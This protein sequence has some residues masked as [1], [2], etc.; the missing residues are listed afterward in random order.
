MP[1]EH[2]HSRNC[3][4][5]AVMKNQSRFR[6]LYNHLKT[7]CTVTSSVEFQADPM[8]QGMSIVEKR[9]FLIFSASFCQVLKSPKSL[10]AKVPTLEKQIFTK[11]QNHGNK[12]E[13][14]E[15]LAFLLCSFRKS[16]IPSQIPSSKLQCTW[17]L[18]LSLE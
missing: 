6:S 15:N 1:F 5:A 12:L 13:I 8:I 14:R 7:R 18:S 4:K 11:I 10:L 2:F 17:S 3:K 16:S 9:G